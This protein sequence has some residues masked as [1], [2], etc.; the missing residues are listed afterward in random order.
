MSNHL[1]TNFIYNIFKFIYGIINP[2]S[3]VKQQKDLIINLR[4]YFK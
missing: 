3:F 1:H 2:L 4:N